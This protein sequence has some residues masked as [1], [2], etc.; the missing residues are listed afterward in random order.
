[1]R[2]VIKRP[3]GTEEVVEGTAEEIAEYERNIREGNRPRNKKPPV[4]RGAEVDGK[5]LTD[6]EVAA[7]RLMR[8][9][10]L[11][12]K[13]IVK[14]PYPY[15]ITYP[16]IWLQP[17]K[18]PCRFCGVIDCMQTHI[19]CETRTITTDNTAGLLSSLTCSNPYPGQITLTQ[20]ADAPEMYPGFQILS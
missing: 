4:L 20:I 17:V 13:E 11:P 8:M 9:G 15:P 10:L 6:A 7:V 19:W 5:P 18:Q 16:P 2:K 12:Q 14:E 3:D 1:M